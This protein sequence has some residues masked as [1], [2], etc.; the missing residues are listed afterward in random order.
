MNQD[1]GNNKY[2]KNAKKLVGTPYP[3]KAE[4]TAL[5]SNYKTRLANKSKSIMGLNFEGFKTQKQAAII[6]KRPGFN[7]PQE[8]PFSRNLFCEF[9]ED[10]SDH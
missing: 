9:G 7:K 1:L 6:V 10:G 4:T 8:S 2:I 3:N 5:L